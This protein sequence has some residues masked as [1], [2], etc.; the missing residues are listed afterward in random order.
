MHSNA[1]YMAIDLKLMENLYF[2]NKLEALF[3]LN[4][5]FVTIV[6]E[7]NHPIRTNTV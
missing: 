2:A 4:T 1:Q 3:E 7:P 5:L 6:F